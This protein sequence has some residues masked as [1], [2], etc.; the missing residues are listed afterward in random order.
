MTLL[1]T[2]VPS[3]LI[4][5]YIYISDKFTEPK[6]LCVKAFIIGIL[7]LHAPSKSSH[8]RGVP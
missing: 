6:G 5:Y 1:L 8:T 3:L 4:A 2:I 7:G